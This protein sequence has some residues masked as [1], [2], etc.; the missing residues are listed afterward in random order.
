MCLLSAET[1]H[2]Q[3]VDEGVSVTILCNVTRSNVPQGSKNMRF[4]WHNPNGTLV[5]NQWFLRLADIRI[6]ESG[7]YVCTV[8]VDVDGIQHE[9]SRGTNIQVKRGKASM[10]IITRASVHLSLKVSPNLPSHGT[11]MRQNE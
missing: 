9:A 10:L 2:T 3:V 1:M 4:Q 8:S 11:R 5:S 6:H 7:V